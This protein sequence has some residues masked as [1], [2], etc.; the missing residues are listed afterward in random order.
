M[1][2]T[3]CLL[4]ISSCLAAYTA[5]AYMDDAD[6]GKLPPGH[7]PVSSSDNMGS[8]H[9]RDAGPIVTGEIVETMD[10]GNYTYVLIRTGDKTLWAATE[11]F[12]AVVGSRVSI[13][14]GMLVKDFE[15]PTLGRKFDELYFADSIEVVDSTDKSPVAGE[16][17]SPEPVEQISPP[18]GGLSVAEVYQRRQE[19][20]GSTVTVRGKVVK[21]T[22]RVM[23]RN[24]LHITDGSGTGSQRDLTINTLDT[25][26]LGDVVTAKGLV[27]IDED[28]GY[29]YFYEVVIKDASVTRE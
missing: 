1:K 11:Q 21:Y 24:W 16:A 27:A 15:S 5:F 28:L 29:G 7:P 6:S 12:N 9:Q 13:P 10:T 4:T 17:T 18:E 20:A 19:I 23:G 2:K 8:A 22:E 3:I 26:R 14:R 25:A